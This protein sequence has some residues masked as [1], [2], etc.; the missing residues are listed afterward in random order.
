MK[1]LTR[2]FSFKMLAMTFAFALMQVIAFAQD[3]GSST[4]SSGSSSTTITETTKTSENWYA[5]PWVW[6]IGAALFILL[7]VALLGGSRGRAT[8]TT[9][10]STTATDTGDRVTVKKTVRRD[11]DT[12][13]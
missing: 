1:Q 5:S 2:P 4:T 9:S 11:T 13:V 12:D 8:S 6:V 7:L 3:S 10:R